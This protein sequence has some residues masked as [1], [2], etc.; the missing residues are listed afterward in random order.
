MDVLDALRILG[1]S[2]GAGWDD[3]RSAYREQLMSHHPDAQGDAAT[4][5]RTEEIVEAY[6][7]LR[8]LTNDGL[9][10]L[11][12]PFHIEADLFDGSP[13]EPG[14]P[15]VLHA[16]PGDVFVRMY[17]AAEQIGHV[18]YA[19]REENV[20]QITIGNEEWAP[21]QLTAELTAQ[22]SLT[23]ALFSLEAL[24]VQEAPPIAEV[25]ARLAD[26]L[27]APAALD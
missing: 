21:S 19:D 6:R 24:G 27:R 3:I 5:E 16:R 22:G 25:V 2:P 18:S 8:A 15:M 4:G 17:Q 20:L 23:T 9:Q 13:G 12:L 14:T 11:P 1:V 26:E 10:P 7:S